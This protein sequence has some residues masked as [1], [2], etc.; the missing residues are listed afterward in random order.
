MNSQSAIQISDLTYT[1]EKAESATLKNINLKIPH[2]KFTAIM[3]ETG[4]G[5]TTFLMSLNG[6]IPQFMEGEIQGQVAVD[7]KLTDEVP[8]QKLIQDIGLVMQ[9]PETQ[10]FGLTVGEDVAFGPSNLNY[11]LEDIEEKIET[12]LMKVGLS[13]YE[14]RSTE[15]LSGG[16]K[17]RLAIA[18]ILAIG[19]NII[20]LDEPTSELDPEGKEDI[21]KIVEELKNDSNMTIVMAE[22]ETEKILAFADHSIVI[23]EGFVVWEGDPKNLFANQKLVEKYRLRP[24]GVARVFWELKKRGFNLGDSCPRSLEDLMKM[25]NEQVLLDGSAIDKEESSKHIDVVQEK[26]LEKEDPKKDPILI[27]E[28]LSHTYENGHEALQ[29]INLTVNEGDFVAI[30]G[31]NGAG[32]STLCKHFNNLLSPTKG[33]VLYRGKDI[34]EKT[35]SELAQNIGYVFQNPDHQIFCTSVI[36]EVMYGLKVKKVSESERKKKALEVLEFVGL[37]EHAEKHPYTLSKGLRQRLAVASILV[38]EPEVLIIDEPTT[39]QDWQGIQDILSLIKKLNDFGHTII[40]ITHNMEIVTEYADR[41]FIMGNG[42]LLKDCPPDQ[43][44][45]DKN[46]LKQAKITPPQL[47]QLADQLGINEHITTSSKLVSCILRRPQHHV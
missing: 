31:Q 21:F 19:P 46:I 13:G 16:E 47:T 23:Q 25:I 11:T 45:F 41:V 15:F 37:A 30:I 12:C 20:V 18:G 43:T 5:K 6:L 24:P 29:D 9:D 40:V 3:G 1:Y 7:T 28:D 22:H 39:G 27:V 2:G 42:S 17:Q 10:I 8:I 4:S 33:K 38:L 36:E 14:D 44:F 34:S 32:K 35:T 26:L